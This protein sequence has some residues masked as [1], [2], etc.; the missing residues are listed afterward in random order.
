M[1]GGRGTRR[2]EKLK[3]QR[4]SPLREQAS[5]LRSHYPAAKH[6]RKN[7]LIA[8]MIHYQRKCA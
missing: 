7:S 4:P 5:I 8:T 3:T 6:S 2:E 1:K